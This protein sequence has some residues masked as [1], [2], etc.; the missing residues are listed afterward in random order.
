MDTQWCFQL[1]KEHFFRAQLLGVEIDAPAAFLRLSP[2]WGIPHPKNHLITLK[3]T[4]KAVQLTSN[5]F[6]SADRT[7][8]SRPQHSTVTA[9]PSMLQH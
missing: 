2:N 6:I 4:L 9:R 8:P 5:K 1:E 3:V 7:K